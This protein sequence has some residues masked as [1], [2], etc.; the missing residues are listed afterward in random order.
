MKTLT[1]FFFLLFLA[2]A[3]LAQVPGFY[4]TTTSG[5]PDDTGTIFKAAPDGTG[6][7]TIKSFTYSTPGASG[8]EIAIQA[9]QSPAG[10][11]YGVTSRGGK[12]GSGVIYEYD[13]A[14]STYV[15]RYNFD[16]TTGH[17][18]Y[19]TLVPGPSGKLYGITSSGGV[20]NKG[21]IYEFDY[22]SGNYAAKAE[23]DGTNGANASGGSLYLH[24][25]GKF[26][27]VTSFGGSVGGGVIF[28][29]DPATSVLTKK[30]DFTGANGRFPYSSLI[31][32]GTKLYGATLQGGTSNVGTFFEYDPVANTLTKKVD[33][34]SAGGSFPVTAPILANNGNL[35]GLTSGGGA[36]GAGVIYEYNPT[37]NVYTKKMD[38][39][40]TTGYAGLGGMIMM[41]N[42]KLYGTMSTGG[43]LDA[44]VIFEYD[45]SNNTYTTKF[46]FDRD[47]DTDYSP[48]GYASRAALSLASNGLL[49]GATSFGGSSGRGT[50][51]E[52][53]PA[54]AAFSKKVDFNDAPSGIH[55]Y[56]G[57]M[58][59]S[60]GKLYGVTNVGG[61]YGG[62]VLFE[63]DPVTDSFTKKYDFNRE[64]GSYPRGILAE[65]SNGKLFGLTSIG[66]DND[67]GTLFEFD[68]VSEVFTKKYDFDENAATGKSPYG[69]LM[70]ASNNKFYGMTTQGGNTLYGAIF[71][72]DPEQNVVTHLADF[73]PTTIGSAAVGD[74]IQAANGKLYGLAGNGG[75]NGAG[76][77]VLFEFDLA[78]NAIASKVNFEGPN[79]S[80]PQ[81]SLLQAPNGKLYGLTFRGGT[82]NAGVLF[83]FDPATG[84]YT[85]KYDF[86]V[87][88]GDGLVPLGSL[89]LSPNG[90]LYGAAPQG[91][92]NGKGTLFEFDP[93]TGAVSTTHN[94]NG[95][96]GSQSTY[97]RLLFVKGGQS[98]AFDPIANKVVGDPS[99][100]LSASSTSGLG[101]VY[102][103]SNL[104]VATISGNTVT[105]VGTGT[106]T[107][108]ASQPG[109]ESYLP[110]ISV[111]RIFTVVKKTQSITFTGIT[112]K[113]LGDPKFNL[114]ATASSSLA[115][116]YSTTSDKVTISGSEVT[117]VKAGRVSISASQAGNAEFDAAVS[118]D[119]SF[120]IK[121]ATPVVTVSGLDTV[122]PT[123]T[124]NT[125]VGNQWFLNGT[126]INGATS[127]TYSATQ[128]G[129]YSVRSTID[130]CQSNISAQQILVVTGDIEHSPASVID[131]YPNPVS[132]KLVISFGNLAGR[133]SVRLMDLQGR[134]LHSHQTESLETE[135]F[136]GSQPVGVYI[137]SVE[138]DGKV[139]H[140][141]VVK[142]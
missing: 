15:V 57:L 30:I 45:P 128:P 107:I 101:I 64:G 117:M 42:G 90:K 25:N 38:C 32:V 142:Q 79:G 77:G 140:L 68:P 83:E 137:V 55:P 70:R 123:L 119:K 138:A 110:A 35:Y 18:P 122:S 34:T 93:A 112:D 60:N 13:P 85:R 5:G 9:W 2:S 98:V 10:K 69:S 61:A 27:G 37:T 75:L 125:T 94:F 130:D 129:A 91:G 80:S 48:T 124:S 19:S 54:T 103:S 28:E 12:N 109:N 4:G 36:S 44:G 104:N 39:T 97:G 102:T 82:D 131:A 53:N 76:L 84:S 23:F 33:F 78:T 81:G 59:A 87:A 58:K 16:R 89:A 113:T 92:T 7:A 115:V 96:D 136:M 66:G 120:C 56:S 40:T 50:F 51:F 135:V 67:D 31:G 47:E 116:T 99:F 14:T 3:S 6:F 106:T 127:S 132:E 17:T 62:G 46:D 43:A 139:S 111:E 52:F 95:T 71:E 20:P 72:F 108:T 11:L 29:F 21:V 133:K 24:T 105:I 114:S 134:T 74:L 8:D 41:P 126:A 118:V 86:T 63:V 100:V 88:N 1:N 73:D 65:G 121:P 22:V 141:R 26:Y 49:Y